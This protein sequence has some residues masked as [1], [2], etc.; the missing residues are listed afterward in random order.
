MQER[1]TAM[2]A[3]L[4]GTLAVISSQSGRMRSR[5]TWPPAACGSTESA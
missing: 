1:V 5:H 2:I 4:L 3:G